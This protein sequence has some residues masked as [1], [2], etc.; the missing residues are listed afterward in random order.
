MHAVRA[1]DAHYEFFG[2][3]PVTSAK[4]I[5][6]SQLPLTLAHTSAGLVAVSY[7]PVQL[8]LELAQL[9]VMVT[10]AVDILLRSGVRDKTFCSQQKPL[11]FTFSS[12]LTTFFEK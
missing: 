6:H 4:F 11:P 5:A 9:T 10:V 12:I 7:I 3:A 1:G 2:S 8:A